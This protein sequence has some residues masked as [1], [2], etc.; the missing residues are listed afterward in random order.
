MAQLLL[1][2][3]IN[4]RFLNLDVSHYA[5]SV[6]VIHQHLEEAD[7]EPIGW[8]NGPLLMDEEYLN[9]ILTVS[10]EI[11]KRADV[12]VVIGIGGSY[13]GA[14]AV[15]EALSPYFKHHEKGIDVIYVGFNLSG[16]YMNQLIES[17]YDKEFY[18]NVISKSGSTM[19]SSLAFRVL[20][21]YAEER[22][23]EEAKNRI[24]VTTDPENSLLKVIAENN[25][26]RKFDIPSN[27]GGRYSLLT[28]VGLLPIAVAGINICELLEGAKKAAID[29]KD[30]S[31]EK[32]EAYRYA[33][34][35][36]ALYTKGYRIEL[37]ASFEPA[38]TSIHEWWKQL[39]GESEGKNKKGLFPAS[40][41][42]STDLHSLG[43][44]V[45]DG[46]PLLFETFLHFKE[47]SD[48]YYIP[49]KTLN[50][51]YLNFL[52]NRTF[53]EINSISK[54]G[55]V[56]AHAEGGV[57]IIQIE[58]DRLDAFHVGYVIYFF[59]K[60]CAMSAYLLDVYPFDQPG[61]EA[62]KK[63][64]TQLLIEESIIH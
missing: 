8:L 44:F 4:E 9:S 16:A 13:L 55:T 46:S 18:I 3:I 31:P 49:Y 41:N 15:Q 56:L 64:I 5:S 62:Y 19:E 23:K 57:P 1:T 14:K 43:Q 25:G 32:N 30:S 63:K 24:I 21:Q 59:M 2:T 34:I 7:N 47:I 12:L 37:L 28:S 61:V 26:Y 45:Q 50:D 11:K 33:V 54:Q 27:I 22:Y 53:N 29:L 48:D 52:S 36:H 40:V 42:Y 58:V 35:R 60:A 38:L 20:R 6:S 39:F 17:L 51:D 10:D